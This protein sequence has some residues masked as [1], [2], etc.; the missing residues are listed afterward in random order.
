MI[1]NDGIIAYVKVISLDKT[2]HFEKRMVEAFAM[3]H[4]HFGGGSGAMPPKNLAS[5]VLAAKPP[6]P[7]KQEFSPK[8]VS[9]SPVQR[10]M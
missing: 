3:K 6:T 7:K 2:K 10:Y 8:T 4:P 1:G 5:L 9:F